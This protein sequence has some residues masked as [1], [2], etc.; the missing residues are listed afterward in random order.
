MEKP[1]MI[2]EHC[3]HYSLI[4]PG[5]GFGSCRV[6]EEHLTVVDDNSTCE[7]YK[8]HCSLRGCLEEK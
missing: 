5:F 3:E 8:P 6:V 2:C 7:K 1:D 4:H